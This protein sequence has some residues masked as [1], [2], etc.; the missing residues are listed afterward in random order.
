MLFLCPD[1]EWQINIRNIFHVIASMW[2][3]TCGNNIQY[4]WLNN[5]EAFLVNTLEGPRCHWPEAAACYQSFLTRRPYRGSRF[6]HH[7]LAV[8]VSSLCLRSRHH[9]KRLTDFWWGDA[10]LFSELTQVVQGQPDLFIITCL[11]MTRP[12][13]AMMNLLSLWEEITCCVSSWGSDY[14]ATRRIFDH[15]RGILITRLLDFF[16]WRLPLIL[17][18]ASCDETAALFWT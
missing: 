16:R 12:L 15:L 17:T 9:K 11:K 7:Y 18:A 10:S 1:R 3:Q 2:S 5:P 8:I 4:V 13:C 6:E 14:Q